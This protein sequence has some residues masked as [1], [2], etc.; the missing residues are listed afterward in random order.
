VEIL[1]EF[2]VLRADPE[3]SARLADTLRHDPVA[4]TAALTLLREDKQIELVAAPT[5]RAL[6][7]ETAEF[8]MSYD[9][10]AV[11]IRALSELQDDG[12]SVELHLQ[13]D[14][15]DTHRDLQSQ[16]ILADQIYA[17]LDVP[18]LFVAVRSTIVSGSDS[19]R[20]ILEEREDERAQ[21]LEGL[22]VR[23]QRSRR[24]AVELLLD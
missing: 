19:A 11:K 13:F 18:D 1:F 22:D 15:G 12:L 3:L 20:Q 16:L 6:A 5:L 2:F 23:G 4:A 8:S 17:V 9:E 21:R 24:R 14:E 7:G 10:S